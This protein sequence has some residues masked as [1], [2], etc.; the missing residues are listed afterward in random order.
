MTAETK[1]D[2]P[3][4]DGKL[5]SLEDMF[6]G[7]EDAIKF[8]ETISN[9]SHLYDDLI[10]KDQDISEEF[11][12]Q[13]MW[14]VMVGLPLNKFYQENCRLL[15]PALPMNTR[16]TWPIKRRFSLNMKYLKCE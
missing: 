10:D 11:V 4:W 7:N 5:A 1:D 9:W 12:H 14:E 6:L 15:A 16:Q 13:V 2:L 3:P 8:M